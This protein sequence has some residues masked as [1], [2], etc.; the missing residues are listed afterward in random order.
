MFQKE[1]F[2]PKT[3]NT[4]ADTLLANGLAVV[5]GQMWRQI[6]PEVVEPNIELED[7][8][9][10]YLIRLPG[11]FQKDWIPKI[12][13]FA[14]LPFVKR[15]DTP[16]PEGFTWVRDFVEEREHYF[17]FQKQV[18]SEDDVDP[19]RPDYRTLEFLAGKMQV[20]AYD[21]RH[22]TYQSYNKAALR[23][24]RLRESFSQTLRMILA[25][26]STP[27]DEATDLEKI[28]R[29]WQK[30]VSPD[31]DTRR[32][33]ASAALNP[34]RG[35]GQN[36]PKANYLNTRKN[37]ADYW[38][39]EYLKAVGL[40]EAAMPQLI[41]PPKKSPSDKDWK[42]TD[43][44]VYVVAPKHLSMP[45]SHSVVN[46]LRRLLGSETSIKMDVICLLYFVRAWLQ[47]TETEV[48]RNPSLDIP[49]MSPSKFVA[50]LHVVQFKMLSRQS[51]TMVNQSFLR[52]PSWCGRL[53]S[54]QDINALQQ[55]IDEHIQI[56]REIDETHSDGYDLLRNYRNFV[57]GENWE[58]FFDFAAAYAH[59]IMRRYNQG[60]NWVPTFSTTHLRRLFMSSKKPL[61]AILENQGFQNM[62]YAIRHSTIIPQYWK[63]ESKRGNTSAISLY[64]V[65]Y[66]LGAELKRKATVRDE[67]VV[68]LM[69]FAHS[70]NQENSQVLENL[71]QAELE[72]NRKFLRKN[73]GTTDVDEVIRLVDDEQYGAEL[74]AN[75]LVAYGYAREPREKQ[76]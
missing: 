43:W 64:E 32:L 62:A 45:V 36:H 10:Y 29:E 57:A 13:F 14:P 6:T 44:K 65:R 71:S 66:G 17:Q 50:G 26:F 23:W 19:P 24:W 76:E 42:K 7:R 41:R 5:F 9:A 39:F 51:Y 54:R 1:Y 2:V 55:V 67:F 47:Y 15:G 35:Q 4:Y 27:L 60:E 37:L 33:T 70:Y 61:S 48:K 20:T 49:S 38:I 73:L 74:V 40:W 8:G 31:L 56:V 3:S 68:A 52:I 30:R 18:G 69:D 34:M 58:A 46:S 22:K 63:G 53:R 21:S 11:A 75:L 16:I 59:E 12:S 28:V 72:R 25:L